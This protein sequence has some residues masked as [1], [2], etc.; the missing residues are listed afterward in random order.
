MVP[1]DRDTSLQHNQ[2]TKQMSLPAS[3]AT[4]DEMLS[5]FCGSSSQ[6]A[7][8]AGDITAPTSTNVPNS[9]NSP[10][11][12]VNTD[13]IL[14]PDEESK[15]SIEDFLGKIDSNLAKT[16]KYV[17]NRYAFSSQFHLF[18]FEILNYYFAFS[19]FF[20]SSCI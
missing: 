13:N 6:F 12:N 17:K 11:A 1:V 16:K 5:D 14:S 19:S 9:N 10:M 4:P 18:S 3:T 15:K 2:F 8:A 20:F 7:A